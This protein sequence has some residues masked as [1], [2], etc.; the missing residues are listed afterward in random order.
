MEGLLHGIGLKYIIKHW[1]SRIG[2]LCLPIV[3][4]IE[5]SFDCVRFIFI[6][7]YDAMKNYVK[8][9]N[10]TQMLLIVLLILGISKYHFLKEKFQR[11]V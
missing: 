6:Q 8:F 10:V 2:L 11:V 3:F 9:N 5:G 4:D 1:V 7:F